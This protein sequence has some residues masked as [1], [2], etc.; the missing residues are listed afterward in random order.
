MGEA[1]NKSVSVVLL[2]TKGGPAIHP[3]S[4]MPTSS[5][6]K[7]AD[8][9]HVIDCGLGVTQGI[10]NA[11]KRLKELRSIFITHMHSDHYLELGP[12]IH[13]AWTAGLDQPVTIYGPIGINAYL[14][15]FLASMKDDIALRIEDEGRIDLK[16]LID[17]VPLEEGQII[18]SS[19]LT[20][21][22]MRNHHPPLKDSFALCFMTNDKSV[23]FSGDTAPM[24]AMAEFAANCDILV[25]EAML[26]EG[27]QALAK[28]I[29]NADGRLIAHL[30]KS[31]SSASEVGRIASMA[32]AKTLVLNH[33]IPS[34]DPDF[35]DEDWRK[36]VGKTWRGELIIGKDGQ[37]IFA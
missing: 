32:K 15:S 4:P 3:G 23:I 10:V 16:T 22:A 5:I 7:I 31:H 34:D 36:A 9:F 6:L 14:D 29:G 13:T 19:T 27:I 11:G 35:T 2:G 26:E 17:F 37:E 24:D 12:L 1:G 20:V 28:R 21:E 18:K 33:L 25:H 8:A 30:E